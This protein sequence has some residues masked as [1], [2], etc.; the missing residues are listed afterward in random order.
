[1]VSEIILRDVLNMAQTIGIIGTLA[2]TFFFYK[3]HIQHLATD[4][5][6]R[7]LRDLDDK[8]H[9]LNI[10][11][12]QHPE[13]AKVQTNRQIRLDTIYAFDVLLVYQQAFKMYKRRVLKE[14]DWYGWL[15]WMR[16]SFRE[17]TIKEHWKEI[18]VSEWFGPRFR[19]FINNDVIEP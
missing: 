8:V 16:T 2:L 10:M 5:E 3:R 17:G 1:M 18:E 19:N 4:T 9:R 15:H 6:T 11:S 7:I 13:L 12:F 14:N